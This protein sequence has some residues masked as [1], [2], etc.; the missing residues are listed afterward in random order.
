MYCTNSPALH[1]LIDEYQT[2]A[3]REGFL[4]LGDASEALAV[5]RDYALKNWLSDFILRWDT[6][7]ALEEGRFGPDGSEAEHMARALLAILN[8]PRN[9][10]IDAARTAARVALKAVLK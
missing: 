5:T 4:D 2:K 6:T 10:S 8:V 9:G 1:A 3:R 7:E